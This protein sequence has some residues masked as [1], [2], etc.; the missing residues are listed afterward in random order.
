MSSAYLILKS[1]A[2]AEQEIKKSRFIA[3][4]RRVEDREA[5][6]A[7]LVEM[8]K[9]HPD[10]VHHCWAF[11]VGHPTGSGLM[12]MS[13]DNE[14]HG[15]AGRPML[16]ALKYAG[17]G[18]IAAVVV[19]YWGGTKL[20]TGGLVRAYSGTVRLALDTAELTEKEEMTFLEFQVSYAAE[21]PVR[22]LFGEFD[23]PEPSPNY[24]AD[25]PVFTVEMPLRI[26]AEFTER[27]RDI[28]NGQVSIK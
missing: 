11:I 2:Q 1:D 18:D 17:V 13:D 12:G 24:N 19:R 14:P 7:F 10:A 26:S 28:T 25:G 21:P 23:L 8:R 16:D 27:L 9:K 3:Y 6:T 22:R 15:T 5:A 4:L 20:G